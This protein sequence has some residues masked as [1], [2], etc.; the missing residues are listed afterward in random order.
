M[1]SIYCFLCIH[2][3]TLRRLADGAVQIA[4]VTCRQ[5]RHPSMMARNISTT[6][7]TV[8]NVLIPLALLSRSCHGVQRCFPSVSISESRADG[9]TTLQASLLNLPAV[10]P[11]AVGM[12]A[13]LTGT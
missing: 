3:Y 6:S 1:A 11:V 4:Q 2:L 12:T 5:L 10:A 13:R 7:T 9:I 8:Q